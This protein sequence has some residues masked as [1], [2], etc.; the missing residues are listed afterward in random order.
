MVFTP[1][2]FLGVAIASWPEWDLNPQIEFCSD[3]LID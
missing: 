1:E 2:G 3:A